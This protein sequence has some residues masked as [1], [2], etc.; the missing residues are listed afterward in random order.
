MQN[1]Y[2]LLDATRVSQKFCFCGIT[3]SHMPAPWV[4][5]MV[6]E[7]E[8]LRLTAFQAPIFHMWVPSGH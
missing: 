3:P 8:S 7:L 6:G 1:F 5:S 4:P 2:R